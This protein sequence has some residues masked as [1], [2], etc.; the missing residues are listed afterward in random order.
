MLYMQYHCA[1]ESTF[2]RTHTKIVAAGIVF[3]LAL[4]AVFVSW[5]ENRSSPPT[6]LQSLRPPATKRLGLNPDK[7]I[8]DTGFISSQ[9]AEEHTSQNE[10]LDR[11]LDRARQV[12]EKK[13]AEIT[14]QKATERSAEIERLDK[15]SI[16]ETVL[17]AIESNANSVAHGSM[18]SDPQQL[19]H[20]YEVQPPWCK[21]IQVAREGTPEEKTNLRSLILDYYKNDFPS[22]PSFAEEGSEWS[23]AKDFPGGAE[24]FPLVLDLLETNSADFVLM[25]DV[26][27]QVH[28]ASIAKMDALSMEHSGRIIPA[29]TEYTAT[30]AALDSLNRLQTSQLDFADPESLAGFEALREELLTKLKD[31]QFNRFQIDSSAV[32]SDLNRLAQ[33]IAQTKHG[34][35]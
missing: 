23:P 26:A 9:K 21:I 11:V 25:A 4:V 2:M 24:V 34:A 18:C 20:F 32:I 14:R 8:Q 15:Q 10:F 5:K 33:L 7:E 35:E 16:E 17:E 6:D 30:F 19:L 13:V 22:L 29:L 1:S 27:N 3:L 28:E 12:D 31:S